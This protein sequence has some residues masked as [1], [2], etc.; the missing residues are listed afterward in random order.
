MDINKKKL[1]VDEIDIMNSNN[2]P[3]ISTL[4]IKEK[5]DKTNFFRLGRY[6]REAASIYRSKVYKNLIKKN[7]NYKDIYVVDNIDHLRH[8]KYIYRDSDFGFFNRNNVWLIL[9]GY[10]S[11]MS[12][13]DKKKFE[14][15]NYRKIE[16][17]EKINIEMKDMNGI[18]GM[19]WSKPSYGRTIK[20]RGSWTEGYSSSLLFTLDDKAN[21]IKISVDKIIFKNQDLS[22]I[23]IY[24]NDIKL[25]NIQIKDTKEIYIDL[26]NE[27]FKN[28]VNIITFNIKNPITPF[29]LLESV[30]GRLLGLLIKQVEFQ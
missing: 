13:K 1:I 12:L 5:F 4:L 25:T 17:K 18:L 10:K 23:D 26:K 28:D 2:F 11:Q 6:N 16:L 27:K 7:I 30:D 19:G 3:V 9:P 24:L 15:I 14:M 20:S 22:G 21:L 8:L 29:S